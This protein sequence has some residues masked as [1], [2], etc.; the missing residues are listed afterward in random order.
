MPAAASCREKRR[1]QACALQNGAWSAEFATA[2]LGEACFALPNYSLLTV[3]GSVRVGDLFNALA[4]LVDMLAQ[5][6]FGQ[7]R[8]LTFKR[9]DDLGVLADRLV[10][11]VG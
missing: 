6:A 7:V 5:E 11:S 4:P 8:V 2:L 10:H 9:V 1:K 3:S